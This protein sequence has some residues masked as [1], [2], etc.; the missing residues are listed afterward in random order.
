MRKAFVEDIF[1]KKPSCLLRSPGRGH[2]WQVMPVRCSRGSVHS[3]T[4]YILQHDWGVSGRK[5][6]IEDIFYV[7]SVAEPRDGPGGSGAPLGDFGMGQGFSRSDVSGGVLG[8]STKSSALNEA[9]VIYFVT[10]LR[11][12]YKGIEWK[13]GFVSPSLFFRQ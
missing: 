4:T 1:Y 6:V 2:I 11:A 13:Q 9:F 10:Q 8:A 5:K 3:C 7:W 12:I